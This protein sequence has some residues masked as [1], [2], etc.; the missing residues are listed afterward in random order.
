MKILTLFRH[1]LFLRVLSI[2]ILAP[3]LIGMTWKGDT[4]F[5]AMCVLIFT[6][7]LWEWQKLIQST[8]KNKKASWLIGGGAYI[9]FSF[10]TLIGLYYL[11]DHLIASPSPFE[12]L[13]KGSILLFLIYTIVWSTD[14]GAYIFGKIIGG[15]KLWVR[16]SP[17]KT[18]AGFIGGIFLGII[19]SFLFTY[20]MGLKLTIDHPIWVIGGMLSLISHVGDL[21]ESAV[22]RH[23]GVKDFSNIIPGHGGILDRID[24][25][26]LVSIMFYMWLYICHLTK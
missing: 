26:M 11:G 17:N 22:K 13:S 8:Y 6:I 3:L 1:N 15:P 20:Y 5:T 9:L 12:S 10:Y 16:V 18:W 14:T 21:I 4:Y 23:F 24:S 25:L 7:G 2:L 19:A